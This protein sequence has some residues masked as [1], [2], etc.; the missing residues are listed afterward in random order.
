[1]YKQC[2]CCCVNLPPAQ[3]LQLLALKPTRKKKTLGDVSFIH[4][5]PAFST[6]SI[7]QSIPP[8]FHLSSSTPLPDWQTLPVQSAWCLSDDSRALLKH[9][10]VIVSGRRD[11]SEPSGSSYHRWHKF[12][13]ESRQSG[14]QTQ[15]GTAW[16][17]FEHSPHITHTRTHSQIY[18]PVNKPGVRSACYKLI[19]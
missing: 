14:K 12:T 5:Q 7:N 8:D 9:G 11:G 15:V 13:W 18:P 2:D 16:S 1:M 19:K 3:Q 10:G 17:S 4:S 6:S